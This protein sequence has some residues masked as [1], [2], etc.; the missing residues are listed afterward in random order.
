MKIAHL[1][2]SCPYIDGIAY[3]ENL[4][5]RQH[6]NDGH[7]VRVIAS[8]EIYDG[9]GGVTYVDPSTY[10]G[11]DGAVV[12]RLAYAW[13]LPA[14]LARKL[15]YHPGLE[16]MLHEFSPDVLIFHGCAGH[17]IVTA[18][19]YAQR[20][21]EVLFY[22]DSHE[23]FNNSA[24]TW[25]SRWI[26]HWLFYRRRFLKALPHVRKVLCL[27]TESMDFIADFYGAPRDKVEFFPLGGFVVDPNDAAERRSR[28]RGDLN[29][30][31]G[32]LVFLQS[33]KITPRKKLLESLKAFLTVKGDDKLFLIVGLL[34][35]A[36]RADV[37]L[38]MNEDDRIRFLG[39]KTPEELTDLLCAV[40]VYVQPGTQS[41]TMQ[42]AL[43]C[44]CPVI[45]DDAPAHKAYLGAGVTLV[46]DMKTLCDAMTAAAS[47]DHHA[48]REGARAFAAAF[49]DYRV[50]AK[51][52][53]T[54]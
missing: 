10:H 53:L 5:V 49:L 27:S 13:W 34:T 51:R 15:R 36:V 35:E 52:V 19:R 54:Q 43:C 7:D 23:D 46:H 12:H 11:G 38:L 29:I 37:E 18:A 24:R 42:H 45:I 22:A 50:L 31:E 16:A 30:P 8:T 1:C 40:D 21:P 4:L 47:W 32:S 9:K 44:G 17:E 20:K 28:L 2:L 39:W 3:Q 14:R 26:L 33:G 48:K 25:A 41:A 6:V